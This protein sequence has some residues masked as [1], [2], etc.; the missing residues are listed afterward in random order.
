MNYAVIFESGARQY[1]AAVGD[2]VRV[3]RLDGATGDKVEFDHVLLLR[4]G[5][6]VTPGRPFVEGARIVGEIVKQG[7]DGKIVVFKHKK[8]AAYRRKNGHC[9]PHTLVRIVDIRS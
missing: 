3:E 2:V 1:A 5:E 6:T 8:R 4:Q 7:R 9:Q